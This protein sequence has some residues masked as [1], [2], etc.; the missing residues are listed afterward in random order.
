VKLLVERGADL[1]FPADQPPLLEALQQDEIEV[2]EYLISKGADVNAISRTGNSSLMV[3]CETRDVWIVELL[4][5][6]GADPNYTDEEGDHAL[7]EAA[8]MGATRIISE[9]LR[10]GAAINL[11]DNEGWTPLMK[12]AVSGFPGTVE[13]LCQ[14]GA[15][16]SQENEYGRTAM[17]YARGISGTGDIST[18]GD[19]R[20]AT[21]QGIIDQEEAYYVLMRTGSGRD[22]EAVVRVL[23]AY[24]D[25]TSSSNATESLEAP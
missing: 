2:A 18:V 8:G 1:E 9:L 13:V 11:Q 17:A 4:L 15:D 10:H 24:Q 19:I 12:A 16:P 5:K 20:S 23:E 25:G 7:L 21:E 3:A 14:A 22:Y 6:N